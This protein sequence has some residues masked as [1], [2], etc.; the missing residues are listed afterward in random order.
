MRPT[1]RW[2]LRASVLVACVSSAAVMAQGTA[3]KSLR[4]IVAFPAG[5]GADILM[6]IVSP[7]VSERIGQNLVIENRP[8]ASGLIGAQVAVTAAPDCQTVTLATS[9][10][11]SVMPSMVS[12]PPYDPLTD[13]SPIAMIATAPLMLTV[14]PS[15]PARSVRE[16]IAL[17]KAK[18]RELLFATN[19]AGSISHLA[20]ELFQDAGGI[21]M[22][23]VPYKGG[24]PAAT[25]TI[26]GH[27]SLIITAIPTLSAHVQAGRL[28]GLGVTGASRSKLFPELPAIAESGLPG[29]SA[30]QWYGLLGPKG[31]SQECVAG[32][33]RHFS[34]A[35]GA[36]D[37]SDRFLK[38]GSEP[39]PMM[40]A[41]FAA[42]IRA[43]VEKW[44]RVIKS[45]NIKLN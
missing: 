1:T 43:D 5:G 40:A 37:V 24:T 38:S 16:L 2:L 31:L 14:H 8:G 39:A 33:N 7:A 22:T 17:A 27:V 23:H 4:V 32:L 9:S 28:R 10:N 12:K 6:R 36:A 13:F 18:P 20:T 29:Y 34:A 45:K 3:S 21:E 25:D 41:D 42:F 44:A 35:L 15:L 19:G 11:F 26:A 30:I